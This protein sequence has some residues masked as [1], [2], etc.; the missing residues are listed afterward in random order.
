M[1]KKRVLCCLQEGIRPGLLVGLLFPPA[2]AVYVRVCVHGTRCALSFPKPNNSPLAPVL[3][4]H[5]RGLCLCLVAKDA[6]NK[7][8]CTAARR[9][10][11]RC[12]HT[13]VM[14]DAFVFF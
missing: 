12:T 10:A 13:H 8:C 14:I 3:G 5:A 2:P 4:C 6:S 9:M 7:R 11:A 1:A